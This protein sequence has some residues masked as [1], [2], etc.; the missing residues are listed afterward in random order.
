MEVPA[1]L[2]KLRSRHI[3]NLRVVTTRS[4]LLTLLPSNGIVGEV[5]VDEG[6]YS[7]KILTLSK[8]KRLHLI[9]AWGSKR[10]GDVKLN[11]VQRRFRAEIECGQVVINRGLSW[12]ELEKFPDEYF[13]WVYLDTSHSYEDTTRELEISRLKVKP[14]GLIGGHDYTTGNIKLPLKYGVIQAVNEFC[15]RYDW[16]MIYLTHEPSRYLTYVMRRL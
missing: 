15:L 7:E 6:K 13:D 16:E 1:K 12:D 9:D 2:P 10:F 3:N 14:C 5:G 8:P 11:E 4:K